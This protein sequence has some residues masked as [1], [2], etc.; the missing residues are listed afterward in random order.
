MGEN[1]EF[2]EK[3]DTRN[4]KK[5]VIIVSKMYKNH[6]DDEDFLTGWVSKRKE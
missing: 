6:V 4:A 2:I 5:A 3:K 1:F